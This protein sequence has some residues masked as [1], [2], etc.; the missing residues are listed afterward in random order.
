MQFD[1]PDAP[2]VIDSASEFGKQEPTNVDADDN[3]DKM[4]VDIPQETSIAFTSNAQNT[5]TEEYE[6]EESK[7]ELGEDEELK[8]I[9]EDDPSFDENY[10]S[11][12]DPD[13]SNDDF[14]TSALINGD[15]FNMEIDDL[16]YSKDVE[17][18]SNQQE[19]K[20]EEEEEEEQKK[21][22]NYLK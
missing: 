7:Q 14:D 8:H 16:D 3:Q 21:I 17:S 15:D 12:N 22:L 13:K 1:I 2:D 10:N 9:Q 20:P 18:E 4:D 11:N 19:G 6:K 5:N